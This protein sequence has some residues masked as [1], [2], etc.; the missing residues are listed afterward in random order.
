[1]DV[2]RRSAHATATELEKP[3]GRF[4]RSALDLSS[5]RNAGTTQQAANQKIAPQQRKELLHHSRRITC[6]Q[7]ARGPRPNEQL[8]ERVAIDET[9]GAERGSNFGRPLGLR[10]RKPVHR[11]GGRFAHLADDGCAEHSI[12][13][14]VSSNDR[15]APNPVVP[16]RS[17]FDPTPAESCS[18]A[19]GSIQGGLPAIS[20][21]HRNKA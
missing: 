1:M 20:S 2:C 4:G 21:C 18:L 3:G 17:A 13:R 14:D 10:D 7:N 6:A 11:C 19:D 9:V 8:L 15:F 12:R 5:G 16:S